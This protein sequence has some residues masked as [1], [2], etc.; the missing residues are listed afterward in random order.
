M[1]N[2]VQ[3]WAHVAD[4][5]PESRR[6]LRPAWYKAWDAA[7][8]DDR[9]WRRPVRYVPVE[10]GAGSACVLPL[11]TQRAGPFPFASLCGSYF[12][13]RGIPFCGDPA[14]LAAACLPVLRNE[15][16]AAGVRLGPVPEDD[17]LLGALAPELERAGWQLLR[18]RIG[19][20]FVLENPGGLDAYQSSLSGNRRK[21]VEYYWRKLHEAG[22]TELH[23]FTDAGADWPA[24]LHDIQT[25]EAASWVARTGEPRFLGA[26]NGAYW[27][28]L[29]AD[30]WFGR[31][32]NVWLIHHDGAPVSFAL[33]LDSGGTRYVIANSFDERVARYSTGAKIYQQLIFDAFGRGMKAINIGL[34][35]SGYKSGWGAR[36]ASPLIDIIAFAPTLR[37][38]AARLAAW[39]RDAVRTEGG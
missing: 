16:A 39:V 10:D 9:N 30:P 5:G 23:H 24:I 3:D 34:G 35:D 8:G 33:T 6:F 32:I 18:R 13:S 12:P 29:T 37:G 21:K 36:P 4:T 19:T 11:A 25:V 1:Q 26:R 7:Y 20:E 22:A 31:A 17:P 15:G 28:R 27:T 14:R 38:R 2:R